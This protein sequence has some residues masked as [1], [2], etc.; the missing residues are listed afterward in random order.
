MEVR[1]MIP[2]GFL[3]GGSISAAQAEGAWDEGGRGPVQVD[4]A[5]AGTAIESRKV[6]YRK[7]D[8]DRDSCPVT[9]RIPKDALYQLFDDVHY[10]NHTGADFYHRYK[11][12]IALFAEMGFKTFNTTISWARIYPNGKAGG[13]NKEGVSFYHD[14]FKECRRYGIDPIITLYKYDEPV[15]FEK[16]YGGWSNRGMIDEFVAFAKLCLEEYSCYIN[17]WITFNEINVSLLFTQD[18]ADSQ[19]NQEKY[20]ELHNQMLA[21]AKV[22][23]MAH[24]KDP[25]IKVGCMI[26]GVCDY[27]L[28][29]DPKDVMEAY[30]FFQNNFAYCADTMMR[31]AYPSYAE[32]IWKE[33]GV[34]LAVSLQDK[35]I[36][37]EGQADFLSFSYY[38]SLCITTH[39]DEGENSGGNVF[40]GR[41]N[42]YL[43]YSDWGWAM[44]PLGFKYFL[45]ILN[46][47]Y[48]KPLFVVEN[49]LGAYDK[50]SEDGKIHDEYRISY[51]K[52][53]IAAMKE[54]IEEG[55]N[56]F[57]Y[58][59][60][61][62]LDLVSFSTGQMDKRYGFLY[63]DMNDKGEGNLRRIKKD[64]FYWYQK[65][66]ESNGEV[67]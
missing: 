11:E 64:S 8:G 6:Y 55:V 29:C 37:E 43:T 33:K 16:A 38:M 50:I 15:F 35:Q 53:H 63:V 39:K 9:K 27:P 18:G 17:K 34:E 22:V 1:K 65:V 40:T 30:R 20:E 5:N 56:L 41:K 47:R 45:H 51:L 31:G 66:I 23:K 57:G 26:A 62:C 19:L 25:E 59:T 10:P 52:E 21:A 3:W 2:K 12:D 28:T 42:P 48:Q 67:L 60:W 54:A 49:G 61:G 46:D 32:R 14:L 44:D 4:F 36:L 7:K 58:T 13:A 24:D